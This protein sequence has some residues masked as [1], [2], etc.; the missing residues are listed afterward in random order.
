MEMDA[1]VD[2]EKH[3]CEAQVQAQ[4]QLDD[5]LNSAGPSVP[6]R[7]LILAAGGTL[8]DEHYVYLQFLPSS[9]GLDFVDIVHSALLGNANAQAL[10]VQIICV[11][12][13]QCSVPCWS[14]WQCRGHGG[15]SVCMRGQC[16][17]VDSDGDFIPDACDNC[18][19]VFNHAQRDVDG[20]SVGDACDNCQS[21]ANRDQADRD[22]DGV[23]DVCDNCPLYW[24]PRLTDADGN[25]YQED[26]DGDDVGDIC[27]TA[28]DVANPAVRPW[29]VLYKLGDLDAPSLVEPAQP[30]CDWRYQHFIG[31]TG[32]DLTS[33]GDITDPNNGPVADITRYGA[34]MACGFVE[35]TVTP[36]AN[37]VSL[38]YKPVFD[39]Y[40]TTITD[41]SPGPTRVPNWGVV[42][43]FYCS[44][45]GTTDEA[46]C[47]ALQCKQNAT[48]DFDWTLM[49]GWLGAQWSATDPST[50]NVTTC[51]SR[52][53]GPGAWSTTSFCNEWLP[54]N[55]AWPA[56]YEI[57]LSVGSRTGYKTPTGDAD[58][59][60]Y[61]EA[62]RAAW[63]NYWTK[64]ATAG[65]PAV[66]FPHAG[67]FHWEWW[68]DLFTTDTPDTL[69]QRQQY[70]DTHDGKLAFDPFG[71]PFY[72]FDNFPQSEAKPIVYLRTTWWPSVWASRDEHS[73]SRKLDFADLFH[74]PG[75]TWIPPLA[76]CEPGC[77]P[78]RWIP[79]WNPAPNVARVGADPVPVM[80]V[81]LD[82]SALVLNSD[83][84]WN[85][86]TPTAA[87]G[88]LALLTLDPS[89]GMAV[90]VRPS[91]MAAG[92][93]PFDTAEPA[94]TRLVSAVGAAEFWVSAAGDRT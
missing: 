84:A 40:D 25:L 61:A 69:F 42:Q 56:R 60:A 94:L 71:K 3:R 67:R 45:A 4:Q 28:R 21:V 24:N 83:L 77:T 75:S 86:A 50:G 41:G 2:P 57:N 89:N 74:S 15:A 65:W 85:S 49:S 93:E 1:L 27:D 46:R 72:H 26:A 37:G 22:G 87:T 29:R 38:D 52:T 73:Y 66:Q 62:W 44:C 88:G 80:A 36:D 39:R 70:Y 33:I 19:L 47:V 53:A 63:A 20:D 34:G 78:W 58:P 18:P 35:D 8:V 7:A 76:T 16:S 91:V 64:D 54:A 11:P 51:T 68:H 79:S 81:A 6:T 5:A 82:R 13:Q 10:G 31:K 90:D 92:S 14:D 17:P 23:G 32:F 9:G 55:V 12:D 59:R 43:P 30:V 48:A